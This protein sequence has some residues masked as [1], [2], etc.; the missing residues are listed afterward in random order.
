QLEG[1]I[2]NYFDKTDGRHWQG[3]CFVFDERQSLDPNLKSV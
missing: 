3:R 2:L 1:G